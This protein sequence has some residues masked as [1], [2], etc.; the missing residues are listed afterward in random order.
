MLQPYT[1]SLRC[2]LAQMRREEPVKFALIFLLLVIAVLFII[3]MHYDASLTEMHRTFSRAILC[4]WTYLH[5]KEWVKAVFE[6]N[7]PALQLSE[8][9]AKPGYPKDNNVNYILRRERVAQ[10]WMLSKKGRDA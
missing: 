10:K 6:K 5:G 4:P 1:L 3:A 2:R 8:K 9:Y 7:F